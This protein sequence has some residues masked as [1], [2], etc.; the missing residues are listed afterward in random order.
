MNG[1]VVI[2]INLRD[3][4]RLRLRMMKMCIDYKE[5]PT[6]WIGMYSLPRGGS[7]LLR[8]CYDLILISEIV[9]NP[10]RKLVITVFEFATIVSIFTK[11]ELIFCPNQK[12][13]LFEVI[14]QTWNN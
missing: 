6:R 1:C 3:D 7:H 8:N 2:K 11:I 5:S 12:Y 14:F 10:S 9:A 4:C 13:V